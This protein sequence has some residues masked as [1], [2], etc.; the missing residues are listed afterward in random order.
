M[1]QLFN[2][3]L[4]LN[5]LYSGED[6][7]HHYK[8]GVFH[9]YIKAD[10]KNNIFLTRYECP[11]A[12][13]V[14]FEHLCDFIQDKHLDHLITHL[15]SDFLSSFDLESSTQKYELN[16]SLLH[17]KEALYLYRGDIREVSPIDSKSL[18]CRCMGLDT[19]KL[20]ENFK[21]SKGLKSEIIKTSNIGLICGNCSTEVKKQMLMLQSSLEFFEGKSFELWK[22]DIEIALG[23]FHFYS[24]KEFSGADLRVDQLNLPEVSIKIKTENPEL[25]TAIAKRSLGNYLG[26]ELGQPFD[27]KVVFDN[28]RPK[29]QS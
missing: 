25:D 13:A 5:H 14:Y 18:V 16:L 27:I 20:A 23:E 22:K 1:T 26:Q 10:A 9:L 3:D 7:S 17:L 6:F 4:E 8:S 19:A 2:L 24:P 28:P 15:S 21:S 11:A 12:Y 29:S